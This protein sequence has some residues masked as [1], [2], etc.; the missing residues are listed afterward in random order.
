MPELTHP[1]S[2]RVFPGV[3]R[4]SPLFPFVPS[5]SC[6]V[7]GHHGEEPGFM[8]FTTSL[9]IIADTYEISLRFLCAEQSQASRSITM[10]EM[11]QS[12]HHLSVPL[13]DCL[14]YAWVIHFHSANTPPLTLWSHQHTRIPAPLKYQHGSSAHLIA[15]P[16][17]RAL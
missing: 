2:E 1:H 3:Q 13:L 5:A 6:P 14:H 7:T 4:G 12:L 8:F 15:L 10:S 17:A 11:L 9:Q 16:G